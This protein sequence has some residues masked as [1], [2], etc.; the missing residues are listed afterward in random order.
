MRAY[1]LKAMAEGKVKE[2]V[3]EV[4]DR[5]V[6]TSVRNT[7]IRIYRPKAGR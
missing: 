2:E 6:K 1:Y 4:E 7:L 3:G 5:T